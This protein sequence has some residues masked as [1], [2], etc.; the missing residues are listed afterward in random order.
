MSRIAVV[1]PFR[2]LVLLV[3]PVSYF[4][5]LSRYSDYSVEY[6]G[7]NMAAILSSGIL[8]YS[9]NDLRKNNPVVWITFISLLLLY[10]VRFTWVSLDPEPVRVMLHTPVFNNMIRDES[11]FDGYRYS[12]L[13]FVTYCLATAGLVRNLQGHWEEESRLMNRMEAV[14]PFMVR[15]LTFFLPVFVILL[16]AVAYRYKIGEMGVD[17]GDPLPFRLK[18]IIFYLRLVFIPLAILLLIYMA[19]R[20][21]MYFHSRFAL[22]LFLV[23]GVLDMLIR[24]SR[25][26]LLLCVLLIVLFVMSGG[27]RLLRIEKIAGVF[28]ACAGIVMVPVMTQFRFLRVE[29]GADIV[30]AIISSMADSIINMPEYF[31]RGL[32][33][34]LFRLPGIEAISAM[35]GMGAEPLGQ[36]VF[37]VFRHSQGIA[38]YLTHNVYTIA[39]HKSLLFAPGVVGWFYLVGGSVSVVLGAVIVALASVS[40]WKVIGRARLVTLPVVKTFYMWMMFNVLTEGTIDGMLF[41]FAVGVLGLLSFEIAIRVSSILSGHH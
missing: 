36:N 14:F 4:L 2:W 3:F 1:L 39:P 34:V 8:M 23:H 38:G 13:F 26:P 40:L 25:S 17:P 37:E 24:S 9:L 10:I 35:Q 12:I 5:T 7:Y 21:S 31:M 20:S 27:L 16:A 33:F 32:E 19:E 11:L 28:V 41:M 6:L 30:S 15:A 22:A 29:E 18:G